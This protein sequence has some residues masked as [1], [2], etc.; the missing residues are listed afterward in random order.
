VPD[1]HPV[2]HLTI[3]QVRQLREF[4]DPRAADTLA[5]VMSCGCTKEEAEEFFDTAPAG[6]L[7]GLLEAIFELSGLGEGAQ[8]PGRSG[9]VPRD[10]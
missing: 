9:D 8:F 7:L 2:K 1:L 10:A 3:S 6:A 4:T 5:I